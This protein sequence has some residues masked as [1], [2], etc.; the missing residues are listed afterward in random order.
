MNIILGTAQLMKNY[1]I[2]KKNLKNNQLNKILNYAKN[3]CSYS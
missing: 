3:T 1:G 2:V